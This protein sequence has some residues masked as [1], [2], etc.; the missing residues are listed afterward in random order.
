MLMM[1]FWLTGCMLPPW[2][3][4]ISW[5]VDGV[6]LLTTD[7]T[8]TDHAVSLALDQDCVLWRVVKGEKICKEYHQQ[9]ERGGRHHE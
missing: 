6:V 4:Y 2:V 1:V 7:K 8:P 9:V 5:G 3:S